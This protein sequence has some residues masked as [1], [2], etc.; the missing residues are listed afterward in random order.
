M[1]RKFQ[2]NIIFYFIK[3][4]LPIFN[5]NIFSSI[6][7]FQWVNWSIFSICIKYHNSSQQNFNLKNKK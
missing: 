6:L 7:V 2:K 5:I 3:A 1:S 4:I